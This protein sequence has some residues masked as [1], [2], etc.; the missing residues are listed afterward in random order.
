MF[1]SAGSVYAFVGETIGPRTGFLTGWIMLGTYLVFPA[2]SIS[3]IAVFGVAFLEGTGSRR[4]RPGSRS[5]WR[6]GP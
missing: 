2:V 5:P 4:T 6:A 3:A 1:A